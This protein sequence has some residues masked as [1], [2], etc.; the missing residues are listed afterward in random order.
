MTPKTFHAIAEYVI[1]SIHKHKTAPE[2][3]NL[4]ALIVYLVL[5]RLT[6][7][8]HLLFPKMS[9]GNVTVYFVPR[10]LDYPTKRELPRAF[11]RLD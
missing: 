2:A 11:S 8:A 1:S 6:A 9:F 5:L 10:D 4:G 7:Y 3:T